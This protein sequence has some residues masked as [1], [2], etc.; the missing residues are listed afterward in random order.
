MISKTLLGGFLAALACCTA[1]CSGLKVQ[2]S[3]A[4]PL[5]NKEATR[6]DAPTDQSIRAID[7]SNFAYP[8]TPDLA[9]ADSSKKGFTLKDGDLPEKSDE[10]GMSLFSVVYADAT[11]D[12]AEDAIVVLEVNTNGSAIPHV[13]YAYTLEK[14]QPKLLWAFSSGD[15]ADGG[16]RAIYADQGDL[17]VELYGRGKVL[18]TDLYADDGSRAQTPY[19]Y[20]FT[21]THYKWDGTK[22]NQK[23]APV[24]LSDSKNYGSP[25]M[26]L[27]A[28]GSSKR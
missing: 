24:V 8:L 7:F 16:L 5:P 21:Q 26:P 20:Y 12:G 13:I 27:Y 10:V 14:K 6:K 25:T 9:V 15:R 19:P 28:N 1:A 11:G 22:F 3:G 2:Q 4:S 17:V 18:G 23:G